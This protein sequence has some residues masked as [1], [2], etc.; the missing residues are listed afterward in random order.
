MYRVIKNPDSISIETRRLISCRYKMI[1]KAINQT[2]WNSSSETDHS[3]YVGSYGR[4]TAINTSDIDIIV[5]LPISEKNR[6]DNCSS[7]GQSY[8]LQLVK[9][10]ISETYPRSDIHAD[11]QVVIINFSD[12]I[13]FE[14]VP[15]FKKYNFYTSKYEY[16]YPDSNNGGR[17]RSTYPK[18]E[19]NELD[20]KNDSNHSNGLLKDTCKHIRHLRDNYFSS[21]HLSGILI[22]SFVYEAIGYWHWLRPNEKGSSNEVTYEQTLLNYYNRN[23][24][25]GTCIKNIYAPGSKM[26]VD[27]KDWEILG[28]I[29]KK[30]VE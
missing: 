20:L 26:V 25:Y 16:I 1:T 11:G 15:A 3:L 22:D 6:I 4:G 12:G 8:L 9:G 13:I 17:W 23:T 14:V 24:F 21:Y 28:K 27:T 5:E 7:N 29:L 2:F 30:M 18:E 10:A 19:Q